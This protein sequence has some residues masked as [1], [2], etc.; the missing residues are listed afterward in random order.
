MGKIGSFH[1]VITFLFSDK[2]TKYNHLKEGNFQMMFEIEA[3][4]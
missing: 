1:I 4:Q 2:M 3:Y